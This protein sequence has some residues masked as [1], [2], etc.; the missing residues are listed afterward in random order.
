MKSI[1]ALLF[2]SLCSQA[3]CESFLT[4]HGT[5]L[6][7]HWHPANAIS[8]SD[9]AQM[10]D[11]FVASFLA[12]YRISDAYSARTDESIRDFLADDFDKILHPNLH[13]PKKQLFVSAKA[14]GKMVGYSLFETIDDR[15]AYI[16]ELA[17]SPPF[18]NQGIGKKLTFAVLDKLPEIEKIVLV[19]ERINKV[20]QAFYERLGFA[21]S[22]YTHE[23]YPPEKFCAYE[24]DVCEIRKKTA[25]HL[26]GR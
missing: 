26:F 13:S 5:P 4:K 6:T 2:A 21:S 23:G 10:K 1:P 22:D 14:S 12:A 24:L 16:A 25:D 9:E 7:L 3:P 20:S 11:V 8:A 17:I 19:T 18:W 15:T